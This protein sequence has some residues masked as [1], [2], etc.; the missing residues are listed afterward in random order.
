[1]APERHEELFQGRKS[2][3]QFSDGAQGAVE[4]EEVVWLPPTDSNHEMLIQRVK[5]HI[6]FQ[7]RNLAKFLPLNSVITYLTVLATTA[8]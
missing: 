6:T 7:A 2:E 4:A 5:T 3:E 1:V 8:I